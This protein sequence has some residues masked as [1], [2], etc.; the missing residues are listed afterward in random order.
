M[1][2]AK[3]ESGGA[4]CVGHAWAFGKHRAVDKNPPETKTSKGARERAVGAELVDSP[5]ASV[6]VPGKAF[7]AGEYA[8]VVERIRDLSYD[9]KQ[10]RIRLVEPDTIAFRPGHVIRLGVP[11]CGGRAEV[12]YRSYSLSNPPSES[13]HV[14]LIIR[15][16][17]AGICT[18]WVFT[19]LKEL[20]EVRFKGPYG[21]FALTETDRPMVWIA[22]GS[23]MAPFWGMIRHMR[24]KH[25]GREC[26]YFFGAV[27]RRDLFLTDEL[28]ELERDMPSFRFVPALSAPA[29]EDH[30]EGETGLIT[31]VVERHVRDVSEKEFYLCGSGAMVDAA[32][33]EIEGKGVTKDRIFYDRF[34]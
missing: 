31:E 25:I 30:W 3:V 1:L 15:M 9:I 23:G 22:G 5:D 13:R 24:E 10:V 14:E 34:R 8:G 12:V 18:T 17:P 26:I 33:R 21:K 16:V 11:P 7:P 29:P 32:I 20:D 19:M 27:T 4:G 28:R 6:R 2:S